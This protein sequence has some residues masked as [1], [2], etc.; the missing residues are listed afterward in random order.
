MTIQN[1][2]FVPSVDATRGDS[3]LAAPP[4][5]ARTKTYTIRSI[6]LDGRFRHTVQM[7]F[8]HDAAA[9]AGVEDLLDAWPVELWEGDRLVRCF[10]PRPA[11]HYLP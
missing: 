10:D 9:V 2:T 6:T 1:R 8:V 5:R 4:P 3:A 11:S 7:D